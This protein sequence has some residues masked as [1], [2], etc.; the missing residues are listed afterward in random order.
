MWVIDNH[1]RHDWSKLR[2]PSYLIDPQWAIIGPSIPLAK[3]GG[4]ETKNCEI[5]LDSGLVTR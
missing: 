2:Y 5:P 1:A 3:R 4:N